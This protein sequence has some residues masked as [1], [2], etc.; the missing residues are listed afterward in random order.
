MIESL[1]LVA[2]NSAT[3]DLFVNVGDFSLFWALAAIGGGMFGAAIGGNWAFVMTGFSVF[4][5]W[6]LL[7]G[8]GSDVGL[9]YLAFGPMF[10]PHI[11]FAAGAASAAYCGSKGYLGDLKGR[12][13]DTSLS[14]FKDMNIY[15]IGAVFGLGGY[16]LERTIRLIP[17]LGSHT[18]TVALTVI[19]S[20]IIARLIWGK[21]GLIKWVKPND[22]QC[23]LR[24]QESPLELLC[25]G[26]GGSLFAGGVALM[27]GNY[28]KPFHLENES[29][30][31]LI[32]SNAQSIPF[33]ISAITILFLILGFRIPVTH[34]I[35]ITAGLAAM[36]YYN[37]TDNGV[38]AL[39]IAVIFGVI[40]SF[41][42]E[43]WS[44]LMQ[45]H[46]DTH[47]DPPAATIWIMNTLVVSSGLLF[48]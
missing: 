32:Y 33:A 31:N 11:C 14:K 22:K 36:V 48:L 8:T 23:W 15:L 17:F 20:G 26:I 13:I 27:I 34:H 30:T 39:L 25:V 3:P 43:F 41:M 21:S 16:L 18:D 9:T 28:I 4:L 7:A 38:A 40:A 19:I 2:A 47:V 42:A 45:A 12:D 35:T 5:G 37:V 10:G 46:G 44:R 29:Y 1:S 24:W 6:G